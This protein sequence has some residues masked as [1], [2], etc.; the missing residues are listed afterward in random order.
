MKTRSNTLLEWLQKIGQP[1]VYLAAKRSTFVRGCSVAHLHEHSV[2]HRDFSA[3][4]ARPCF[5]LP[6]HCYCLV[7]LWAKNFVLSAADDVVLVDF[8]LARGVNCVVFGRHF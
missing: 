4:K 8:G 6:Y 2:L 5:I 7:A 1:I 3:R